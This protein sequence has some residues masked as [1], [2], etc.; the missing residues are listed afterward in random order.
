[1]VYAKYLSV[2][3]LKHR[4]LPLGEV[5]EKRTGFEQSISVASPKVTHE[6]YKCQTV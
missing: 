6:L 3:E 5:A 2:V 1:M 4:C